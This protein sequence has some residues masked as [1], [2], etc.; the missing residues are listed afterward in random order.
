MEFASLSHGSAVQNGMDDTHEASGI[1]TGM[2][3]GE[4]P[5][6]PFEKR[7]FGPV[8][9]DCT[10]DF[11][12]PQERS[13]PLSPAAEVAGAPLRDHQKESLVMLLDTPDA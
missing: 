11:P 10:S 13:F 4:S 8:F 5:C 2:P 12:S 9:V 3:P 1:Q 6:N 7:L